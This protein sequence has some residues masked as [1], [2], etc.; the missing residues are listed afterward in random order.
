MAHRKK[1]TD[2]LDADFGPGVAAGP[3]GGTASPPAADAPR[4]G[5]PI[6]GLACGGEGCFLRPAAGL[7][8]RFSVSLAGRA[9]LGRAASSGIE[10]MKALRDFLDEEIALAE[11]AAK[12]GGASRYEKIKVD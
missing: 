11:R 5:G 7:I 2:P 3:A 10:L 1:P 8:G 12:G 9:A 6:P 4:A